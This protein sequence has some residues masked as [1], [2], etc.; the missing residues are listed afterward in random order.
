[1][2]PPLLAH[3]TRDNSHAQHTST[4][5]HNCFVGGRS[6]HR[7]ACL[8]GGWRGQRRRVVPRHRPCNELSGWRPL[9]SCGGAAAI[10]DRRRVS[11]RRAG[12]W[13]GHGRP[14][15]NLHGASWLGC[16]AA[17]AP[18]APWPEQAPLPAR[19]RAARCR[20]AWKPLRLLAALLAAP[21]SVA[22]GKRAPVGMRCSA[23]LEHHGTRWPR[24]RRRALQ[25]RLR[26]MRL[27]GW[28]MAQ[29][30][31]CCCSNAQ[32]P[33]RADR[34]GPAGRRARLDRMYEQMP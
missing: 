9:Q 4:C 11:A 7:R 22:A 17:S 20:A 19:L 15:Y 5:A 32:G 6:R 33:T 26:Q 10:G 34:R 27:M 8:L 12:R 21:P 16:A 24:R 25:N 30:G 23:P 29:R 28:A 31:N 3:C 14:P 2:R 18:R 1:M 13:G